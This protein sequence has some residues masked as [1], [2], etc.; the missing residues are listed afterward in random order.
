MSGVLL[1]FSQSTAKS[2]PALSVSSAGVEQAWSD[3]HGDSVEGGCLFL[4]PVITLW[5]GWG[6]VTASLRSLTGGHT[7]KRGWWEG[8]KLGGGNEPKGRLRLTSQG[9]Q[10]KGR[11]FHLKSTLSYLKTD[12]LK[13]I[14]I[15]LFPCGTLEAEETCLNYGDGGCTQGFNGVRK[16]F[17]PL[18]EAWEEGKGRFFACSAEDLGGCGKI[19]MEGHK[20]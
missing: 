19:G 11:V 9:R 6:R 10:K 8:K 15:C 7:Q 18:K 14:I 16:I 20:E 2:C 4:S 12:F 3:R 17:S 1:I 5:G 13:H